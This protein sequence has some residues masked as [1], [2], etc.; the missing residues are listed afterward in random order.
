MGGLGS[1]RPSGLG[2]AKVEGCRS[3]DANRLHRE[4]CLQP[5]WSGAWQWTRDRERVASINLRAEDGLLHLTYRVSIGGSDWE[6]IGESVRI[7][8]F[9]CRYGG[10]RPFF[11]CPGVVNGRACGRR[12]AKLYLPGRYFVCRDCSRL[13]YASQS[14]GGLDRALRRANGIRQQSRRRPW[15]GLA[16]SEEAKRHVA[17]DLRASSPTDIR[18]RNARRGGDGP[19]HVQARSA[20]RDREPKTE[21]LEMTESK[22]ALS[23]QTTGTEI[24]R[25]NALRHGVLSRYTVLPWENAD[26]YQALVASLVAEHRPHGPTEE[27]LVEELAGVLWRK[28]RLWLA[29]A[30]AH[31]RGLEELV[32][33]VPKHREGSAGSHRGCGRARGCQRGSPHYA[34]RHGKGA[35][36]PQRRRGYDPARARHPGIAKERRLRSGARGIAG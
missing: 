23:A 12:V 36:R 26:E 13:A 20:Y 33:R 1:G 15:N 25:F 14:E 28:R 19:P 10:A 8:H 35:S 31:R 27:H 16:V 29:E 7:V 11:I 4:G 5:G 2:R 32:L 24:T 30:A 34:G 17:P 22:P 18:D 9:A 3:L 21:V 6:D